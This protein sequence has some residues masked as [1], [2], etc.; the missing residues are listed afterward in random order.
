[1]RPENMTDL[2][3]ILWGAKQ[4]WWIIFIVLALAIWFAFTAT[5]RDGKINLIAATAPFWFLPGCAFWAIRKLICLPRTLA[6]RK[7]VNLIKQQLAE[8]QARR[9]AL[10]PKYRE[11]DV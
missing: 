7:R 11:Y 4:Y 1:M 5:D 9:E 2:E 3:F 8:Q 6:R 10:Y